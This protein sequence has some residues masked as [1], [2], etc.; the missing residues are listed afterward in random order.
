MKPKNT[1]L[2]KDILEKCQNILDEA[3]AKI[4]SVC[5]VGDRLSLDANDN[6]IIPYAANGFIRIAGHGELAGVEWSFEQIAEHW[7]DCYSDNLEGLHLM[8]N[9]FRAL[10]DKIDAEVTNRQ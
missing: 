1:D 8:S 7:A 10:A 2:R 6:E 4:E 5:D 3:Y 9:A